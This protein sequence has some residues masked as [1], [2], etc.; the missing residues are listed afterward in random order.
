MLGRKLKMQRGDTMIEVLFA[1]TIFSAV[2]VAG[3]S[4]MNQGAATAQR[5]LE[6][7]LVRQEIDAQA[8]ALRLLYDDTVAQ[9]GLDD[10]TASV[11]VWEDIMDLRKA[12]ASITPFSD[13]VTG[14]GCISPSSVSGAFVINVMTGA[15]A[16]SSGAWRDVAPLSSR[17]IYASSGSISS[18]EGIWIEAAQHSSAGGVPGYT[19]FHIRACWSTIGQEVPMTLGTIVRLYEP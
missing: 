17:V 7:S 13:M 19:D 8:E 1:I 11:S 18:V 10:S 16:T 14:E 9:I 15:V 6:V 2:A 5:S 4:I 12:D 3:L